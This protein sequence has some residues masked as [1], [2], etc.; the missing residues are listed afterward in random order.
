MKQ[1]CQYDGTFR[2]VRHI[3]YVS[4]ACIMHIGVMLLQKR[5]VMVI[6][7]KTHFAK[8]DWKCTTECCRFSA[9]KI[10]SAS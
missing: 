7:L 3:R 1:L 4:V 6:K 9:W 8:A 2:N 5:I 10:S